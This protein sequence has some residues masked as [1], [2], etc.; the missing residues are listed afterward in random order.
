MPEWAMQLLLAL[1]GSASVT[2][3]IGWFFRSRRDD[4]K[5]EEARR[6]AIYA[7]SEARCEKL[8]GKV[9]S[10]L[11]DAI[12]RER[13]NNA[14]MSERIEMDAKQNE[15]ILAATGTLKE[16]AMFLAR[17]EKRR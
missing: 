2:G 6:S 5:E 15:V 13:E 4:R 9:E 11:M 8:Q 17:L 7:A 14:Q 1:I 16:C 12:A 3:G 10:L